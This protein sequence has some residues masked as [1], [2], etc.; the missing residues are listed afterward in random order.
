MKRKRKH[1]SV[2]IVDSII[3]DLRIVRAALVQG[4]K[5]GDQFLISED[6][7]RAIQ[8]AHYGTSALTKSCKPIPQD[9]GITND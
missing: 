6:I 8:R 9:W 7:A 5:R 4:T 1:E 3:A 2:E